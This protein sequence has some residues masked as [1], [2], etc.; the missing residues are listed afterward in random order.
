[1]DFSYL[2]TVLDAYL[3]Q[4]GNTVATD[5]EFISAFNQLEKAHLAQN[6][7]AVDKDL[8]EQ[9]IN[10]KLAF[11]KISGVCAERVRRVERVLKSIQ[12]LINGGSYEEF[13]YYIRSKN[14][15]LVD[16]EITETIDK[17]RGYLHSK[18]LNNET[19][20]YY[21]R[22][23]RK[24]LNYA[25]ISTFSELKELSPE[26][27]IDALS[28]ILRDCPSVST[29]LSSIRYYLKWLYDNK[30]ISK[31]L[32]VVIDFRSP[33]KRPVIKYFNHDLVQSLLQ[34][35]S[36]NKEDILLSSV[37]NLAITTGLR[38]V[39][40]G[41]LRV[42]DIDWQKRTISIIQSKTGVRANL[43]LVESA[44]IPLSKYLLEVRPSSARDYVFCSPRTGQ[45]IKRRGL[46][47][48]FSR[49]RDRV[50]GD[51]FKGYGLHSLRRTIGSSLFQN[52]TDIGLIKDILGHRDFSSLDKYMQADDK[53]LIECNLDLTGKISRKELV[54]D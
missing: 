53:H 2:R 44:A 23:V 16:D 11:I 6:L 34:N 45:P 21:I 19:V 20:S 39:D 37:I 31:D 18:K 30:I 3:K 51:G 22:H 42:S 40:L 12:C 7:H 54:D 13:Y 28:R 24:F 10:A 48:L 49:Y 17:Y 52:E 9:V 38:G 26:C 4:M 47:N 35:L 50:L 36:D 27:V 46:S 43:P 33:R 29:K 1:M 14:N 41:N 25:R 5:N 15:I 8:T 32:S